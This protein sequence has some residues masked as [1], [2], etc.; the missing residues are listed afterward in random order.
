M[1]LRRVIKACYR[2]KSPKKFIKN[3]SELVLILF[4]Y[5]DLIWDHFKDELK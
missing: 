2:M 1:K 4:Y 3:K 5:Q